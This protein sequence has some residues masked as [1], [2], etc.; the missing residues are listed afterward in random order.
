[1]AEGVPLE[2]TTFLCCARR[3]K[4]I[5][6]SSSYVRLASK[7][8]SDSKGCFC[9]NG[10]DSDHELKQAVKEALATTTQ[11]ISNTSK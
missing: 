10:I 4:R 7:S 11:R 8:T 3:T 9:C 2:S 1:M 5:E 6:I